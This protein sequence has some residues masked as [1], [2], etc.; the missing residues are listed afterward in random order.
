MHGCAATAR[1]KGNDVDALTY[2]SW[3]SGAGSLDLGLRIA[4]PG[5]RAIGYVEIEATACEILAARFADGSLDDAPIWSDIRSWPGEL[6]RGR[7]DLAIFG[8]PCQ[9]YS[10]AGQQRGD[11]DDRYLWDHIF[12]AIDASEPTVVFLENVPALLKWFEPIGDRLCSMGYQLT[13]GLFS[14]QEVGAPHKRER[15]FAV[16]HSR[17]T[18][19]GRPKESAD[20]ARD[21]PPD[22]D[23]RAS[24]ALADAERTERRTDQQH[25][26]D[27]SGRQQEAGGP[28]GGSGAMAD[29]SRGLLPLQERKPQERDGSGSGGAQLAVAAG[30][31]SPQR[32][33]RP[34]DSDTPSW[35]SSPEREIG[36][37]REL[38]QPSA[39]HG[40]PDGGGGE[41][42]APYAFP[43]HR[44]GDDQR[45]R[46]VL[47]SRSWLRPALALPEVESDLRR[48]ADG[49]AALLADGRTDA[50]RAVGNGVV[51]LTA[52]LAF[53]QLAT[54]AGLGHWDGASFRFSESH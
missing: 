51:P 19:T 36:G 10:V 29:T 30:A 50:L 49:M 27:Q 8:A 14:A 2:V 25:N 4:C 5:A 47:V 46:E 20:I 32:P 21:G 7:V 13:C 6:Y 26:I 16:A 3:F 52:A 1:R 44:T 53:V 24:R 35:E 33:D 38:R 17:Y 12:R 31:G 15:F 34:G 37:L 45:W 11:Q 23:R 48:M 22:N 9:P 28:R 18:G 42:D 54:A 43:P 39:R 40:Q 41:L